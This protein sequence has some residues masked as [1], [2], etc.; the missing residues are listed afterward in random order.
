MVKKGEDKTMNR[1]FDLI[2]S[3]LKSFDSELDKDH[4]LAII[5]PAFAGSVF[6][7]RFVEDLNEEIVIFHGEGDL[8]EKMQ[9][10]FDKNSFPL[11]LIA[12][13]TSASQPREIFGFGSSTVSA[14]F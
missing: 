1:L 10:V 13:P 7:P 4:N 8:G 5:L 9:V 12:I 2:I 3:Q 14:K 6:R 11:I